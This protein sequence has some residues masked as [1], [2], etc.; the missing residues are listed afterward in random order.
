MAEAI[1]KQL[2]ERDG[3]QNKFEVSSAGTKDW[4]IGLRPDP[5]TQKLL[6]KHGYSLD[7]GKRA[8]MI[9]RSEIKNADFLNVMSNRI[10]QELGYREYVMLLMD[11]TENSRGMD[12]PDPYPT[13]SFPHAFQMIQEGVRGF[14]NQL[15]IQLED[16]ED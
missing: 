12:I 1:F 5:R 10:A 6:L 7:P 9:T 4:D 14:Y 13:D 2:A 11:Y 8:T 16:A 3:V 15:V